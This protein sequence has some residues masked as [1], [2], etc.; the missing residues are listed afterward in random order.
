MRVIECRNV[1]D[2]YSD[3]LNALR[4][5]G[6]METSRAGDVLVYPTPVTIVYN[7]P[8][9]RVLFDPGRDANPF[10]HLFESLWL[11]AG[12]NDATWLDR[13]VK[14]FS[15]RFAEPDGHQ[16]GSY[17]AR[18]R[19]H[20]DVEGGGR[21]GLPD[22]LDTV[23]NLLKA[24]SHDRQVVLQ[25]WDPVAD[26]GVVGLKDKPCNLCVM[27][28]VNAGT[29]DIAVPCRSNDAIWGAFGAN[30][31]H[32]PVLQE[33]LAGRIGVG[34]GRYYQ[35]AN[36]F[37]A[38]AEVFAKV[39]RLGSAAYDPYAEGDVRPA[40]MGEDWDQWD[41]DLQRFMAWTESQEPEQDPQTYPANPWFHETAEPLFIANARWKAGD[42]ARAV[43]I[44]RDH[45]IWPE[46]AQDWRLAALSWCGRR[47]KA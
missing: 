27:L 30:A 41:A 16:H 17:G 14:D 36:N 21:P 38:Y 47:W 4:L 25:M 32:F 7:Q 40:K 1:N 22:Q 45:D 8:R 2:A 11:L 43:G 12:R 19:H 3:G 9:E 33:Y 26:L 31:V 42:K 18:W 15:S 23:V 29:L 10:F 37:H 44:L 6:H 39:M 34:I 24:N 20:F 46:M 28:R 13:F 35:I 5:N